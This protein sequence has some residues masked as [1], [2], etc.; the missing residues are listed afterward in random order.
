M[1]LTIHQKIEAFLSEKRGSY[2]GWARVEPE[3]IHQLHGIIGRLVELK[4]QAD[5]D[6]DSSIEW[7]LIDR[8]KEEHLPYRPIPYD[9]DTLEGLK[10]AFNIAL[11]NLNIAA[12]RIRLGEDLLR[13][14]QEEESNA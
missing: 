1:A 10:E 7:I 9:R 14:I 4:W 8:T 3:D 13:M 6:G 2:G 11:L 12:R 5:P